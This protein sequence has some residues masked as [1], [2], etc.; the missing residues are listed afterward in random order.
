MNL[1]KIS[2]NDLR[3]ISQTPGA[4]LGSTRDKPDKNI[5]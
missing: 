2:K 4:A 5:V 3:I 1:N